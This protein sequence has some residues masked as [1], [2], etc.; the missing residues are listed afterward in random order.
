MDTLIDQ[1]RVAG[2]DNDDIADLTYWQDGRALTQGAAAWDVIQELLRGY[3]E[4]AVNGLLQVDMLETDAGGRDKVLAAHAQAYAVNATMRR[5]TN[6][7]NARIQ[8]AAQVPGALA[9]LR[10]AGTSAAPPESL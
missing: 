10:R 3:I 5:L 1:A 8:A 6:D 2:L 7:V 9:K 4:E